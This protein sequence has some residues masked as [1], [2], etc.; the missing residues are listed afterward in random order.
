MDDFDDD[1]GWWDAWDKWM[2]R[3]VNVLLIFFV[4]YMTWQIF[5]R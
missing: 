1:F 2:L 4:L 3:G 5:F